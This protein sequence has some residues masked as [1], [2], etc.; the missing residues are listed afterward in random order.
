MTTA[1]T[2]DRLLGT[3]AVVVVF[4]TRPNMGTWARAAICRGSINNSC[5]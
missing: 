5:S 4:I 2:M 1:C 3:D